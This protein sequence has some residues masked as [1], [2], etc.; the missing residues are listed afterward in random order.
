MK[1]CP[2]C[3]EQIQDEAKVCRFCN[4]ELRTGQVPSQQVV[5][6]QPAPKRKTSPVAWGCL[7]V[8]LAFG[9]C[10]VLISIGMLGTSSRREQTQSQGTTVS[11]PGAVASKPKTAPPPSG[12]WKTQ[13][14]RSDID[15]TKTVVLV[16][17]ADRAVKGWPGQTEIPRLVLRCQQNKTEVYINTGFQP[18]VESGNLDGATVLLRFDSTQAK[19]FNTSKSTDGE[20]L[21]FGRAIPLIKTM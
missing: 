2:F 17:D 3:A 12:K 14:S 13:T 10:Y 9:G 11:K 19:K 6:Q 16:L 21:F 4:R 18:H 1:K 8:L 5:V 20:A 7:F 15:D